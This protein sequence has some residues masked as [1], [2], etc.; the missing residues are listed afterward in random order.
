MVVAH[1]AGSLR[2]PTVINSDVSRWDTVENANKNVCVSE[3]CLVGSAA[4]VEQPF[5]Q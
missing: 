1:C 4:E 3:S 2:S 5:M